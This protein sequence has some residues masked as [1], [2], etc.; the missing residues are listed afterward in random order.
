MRG[1]LLTS[2]SVPGGDPEPGRAAAGAQ[3]AIGLPRVA[4][5]DAAE[6]ADR[7]LLVGRE[8]QR[9]PDAATEPAT[10]PES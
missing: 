7:G 9:V 1:G 5:V 4:T 3:L 8:R 6:E 2:S 10:S